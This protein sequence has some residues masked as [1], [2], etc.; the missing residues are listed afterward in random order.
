MNWLNRQPR[1]DHH[2]HVSVREDEPFMLPCGETF[3]R[4]ETVHECCRCHARVVSGYD[5]DMTLPPPLPPARW[6]PTEPDTVR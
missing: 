5:R 1:C 3:V 4:R 2:W 6:Y